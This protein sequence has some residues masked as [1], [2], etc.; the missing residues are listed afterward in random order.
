MGDRSFQPAWQANE[1]VSDKTLQILPEDKKA[2][3]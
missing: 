2:W 3:Q 1:M